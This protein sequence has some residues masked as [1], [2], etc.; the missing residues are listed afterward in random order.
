[1]N[2]L[3]RG[4]NGRSLL[5]YLLVSVLVLGVLVYMLTSMSK[6]KTD[7]AYSEIMQ[8]FDSLQVSD[9]TLDLGS[10][11]LPIASRTAS[12]ASRWPPSAC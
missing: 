3:K 4:G 10:G 1:M 5:I 6:N 12:T 8:E 2:G 7:K 9:F 11:K